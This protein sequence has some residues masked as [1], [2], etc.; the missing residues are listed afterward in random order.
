VSAQ[1]VFITG[2]DTGVGKTAIAAGLVRGLVA[3][4]LRVAVMKPVAS[5]SDFTPEGLRN[6]DALKLIEAANVTAPYETV[7]PYCFAPPVAPHI[8]AKQAGILMDTSLV[9]DRFD[10]LAAAADCVVIEGVGGW[11]A[12]LND[13][14]TVADLVRA[15]GIPVVM[16]V[17]L[18][19]GCLNHALLTQ[20]SIESRGIRLAGWVGN[21]ID[22]AMACRAENLATL[23]RRLG[24]PPL[25]VVPFMPGEPA[26][27]E[28]RDAA[29]RLRRR[30]Q[31][32][33]RRA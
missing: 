31:A 21:G 15:L 12:P 25:A 22:P 26:A 6:A 30:L 18:R 7:N 10:S 24:Q 16:V 33:P 2:T 1:G 19:L 32:T 11:L 28:L 13:T 23:E 20:E 5:G 8:A 29:M 3:H 17:G 27:L 14:Q 4:G 9:R